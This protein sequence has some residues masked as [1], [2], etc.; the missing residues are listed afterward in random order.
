MDKLLIDEPNLLSQTHLLTIDFGKFY[1]FMVFRRLLF[2]QM[3][4]YESVNFWKISSNN[5]LD[6]P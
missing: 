4:I 6:K 1:E 2:K 5:C 3:I